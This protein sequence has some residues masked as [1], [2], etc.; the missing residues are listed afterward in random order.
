MSSARGAMLVAVVVGCSA[1]SAAAQPLGTYRWQLQPFCNI[2]TVYVIQQGDTYTLDGTDDRC[3]GGNQPGSVVGIAYMA[4]LGLIGFGMTMVLPNGVPVHTEATISI[5]SLNGTWRD[6]AGNNGN[7]IFTLGAGIGGAQRPHSTTG[8]APASI[9]NVFIAPNAVTGGNV[10]DGSLTIADL[11]DA[12]RA[13][14]VGGGQSVT[15]SNTDAIIRSVSITAPA[16]GRLIANAAGYFFLPDAAE[17]EIARCSI[18]TGTVVDGNF[19]VLGG[20]PAGSGGGTVGYVPLSALRG[21]N[22]A[23]NSSTTVNLVCDATQGSPRV[24]DTNLSVIFIP[25]S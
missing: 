18:T 17:V 3:G 24:L 5:A 2:V 8:L 14:F 23:A 16:A 12:P 7:F 21:F 15:L 10:T 9:T 25:G 11:A 4:P 19:S 1:V 20:E 6:S 13:N 22:V